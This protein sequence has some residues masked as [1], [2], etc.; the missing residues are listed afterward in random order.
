MVMFLG[1][2]SQQGAD[3]FLLQGLTEGFKIG[4]DY[5]SKTVKSAKTNM[6]SVLSHSAV[7]ED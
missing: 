2:P 7:V 5:T 4:Y 1:Y 6:E 3:D